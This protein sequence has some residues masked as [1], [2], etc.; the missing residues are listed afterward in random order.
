MRLNVR[1]KPQ[2]EEGHLLPH[3]LLLTQ[4]DNT[5]PLA[6]MWELKSAGSTHDLA[7]CRGMTTGQSRVPRPDSTSVT[8]AP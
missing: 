4:I 7:G 1:I 3:Q 5:S 2:A 8:A 6:P